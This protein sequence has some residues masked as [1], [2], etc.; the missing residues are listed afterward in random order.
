MK[1]SKSILSILLVCM[2]L[3]LTACGG[4]DN[5]SGSGGANSS[6]GGDGNSEPGAVNTNAGGAGRYVETDVTPEGEEILDMLQ[7]ADGTLVLFTKG[8]T[9]RYDSTDGGKTFTKSDWPG[10]TDGSLDGVRS[11]SMTEDGTVYGVKSDGMDGS[12]ELIRITPEGTVETVPNEAL[13]QMKAD[14]KT[15]FIHALQVLTADKILVGVMDGSGV[16]MSNP[17]TE[18]AEE[19]AGE[20]AEGAGEENPEEDAE[21]GDGDSGGMSFSAGATDNVLGVFDPNTGSKQYDLA[22]TMGFNSAAVYGDNFYLFGYDETISVRSIETG[23]EVGKIEN[24]QPAAGGEEVMTFSMGLSA[25]SQDGKM[26]AQDTKGVYRQDMETGAKTRIFEAAAHSFGIASNMAARFYAVPDEAFVMLIGEKDTNKVY[27]YA[28]DENAKADPDKVLDI[29]ALED[30]GTLRAA[31]SSFLKKNPDATVNLTIGKENQGAQETADILQNLNTQILAGDGPDI[32]L[33]DGL[34]AESYAEKGMLMDLRQLMD[35]SEAYEQ[36]L[37][38]LE[39]EGG[40]YYFPARFKTAL[41]L[42]TADQLGA[43]SD[44]ESMVKAIE[45]GKDKP[46]VS[47]DSTDPFGSLGKEERPVFEFTDLNELFDSLYHTSAGKILEDGA[48]NKDAAKTFL[49]AMKRISDKYKL[50]EAGEEGAGMAVVMSGS[51]DNEVIS[52]NVISYMSG[53]ALSGSFLLGS[54]SYLRMFESEGTEYTIMPGLTDGTYIPSTMMGISAGTDK[55]E[56]AAAFLQHMLT[57]DVQG[58]SGGGFPLTQKG[59]DAQLKD[60]SEMEINGQPSGSITFDMQS[61]IAQLKT[62]VITDQMVLEVVKDAAKAYC[63]GG[64]GLD[65]A[66]TQIEEATK[67]YLAEQS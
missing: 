13:D 53:R 17:D 61:F 7:M 28:Y 51:S 23:K 40:L 2:M 57:E 4:A 8:L 11:I 27:R 48:L 24:N 43:F 47:A 35:F 41:L 15:V 36:L 54:L 37:T 67:L 49:D 50:T 46:V 52:G 18:G 55:T 44:L 29:W 1:K 62:P 34:P 60:L 12:E 66:V 10:V 32:L 9:A 25:L 65:E 20:P 58:V 6:S 63:D 45:S 39:T 38:P 64:I 33:L 56:L 14:G 30:N 22:D 59:F 3:V 31:I 42:T 21:A 5:P 26:Y 19:G 16:M